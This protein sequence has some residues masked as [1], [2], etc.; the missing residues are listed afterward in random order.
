MFFLLS[1]ARSFKRGSYVTRCCIELLAKIL[2]SIE[3]LLNRIFESILITYSKKFSVKVRSLWD[4]I[5]NTH[6]AFLRVLL[7]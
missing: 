6:A 1:D 5:N 4:W 3:S 2:S 7:L